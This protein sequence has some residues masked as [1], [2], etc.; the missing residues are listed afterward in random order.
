LLAGF[1][2]E[3][4]EKILLWSLEQVEDMKTDLPK[5]YEAWNKGDARAFEEFDA[6]TVARHP[7]YK[8]FIAKLVDDR[9]VKMVEKIEGYLK[10]KD[11]HFVVVGAGHLDGAKGIVKALEG[12][13]YKIEQIGKSATPKAAKTG[14]K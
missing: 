3:T 11:V 1:D 7:E 12:K 4:Q 6:K 13:K 8:D 14:E 5:S 9:N 2:D 10:T